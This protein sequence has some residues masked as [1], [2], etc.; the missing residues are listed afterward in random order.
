MQSGAT[1]RSVLRSG[2]HLR[3]SSESLPQRCWTNS[4]IPMTAQILISSS[5]PVERCVCRAS[6]SG[7]A[8]TASFT[9]V[10]PTGQH[11]EKS[12]FS[13]RY[14][15]INDESGGLGTERYSILARVT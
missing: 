3:K 13:E 5:A 15:V 9:F 1:F 12:I 14:G 6:C 8:P 10:T 2:I 7:K 11:S 4:C